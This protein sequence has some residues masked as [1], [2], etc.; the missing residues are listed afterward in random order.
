[1]FY[2]WGPANH[3]KVAPEVRTREKVGKPCRR[4][5]TYANTMCLE[6]M[7]VILHAQWYIDIIG[8][9]DQFQRNAL[10]V[11]RAKTEH[12]NACYYLRYLSWLEIFPGKALKLLK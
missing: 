12:D 8:T 1:M 10:Y 2:L 6:T 11:V 7:W 9:R 3:S 4:E 5:T